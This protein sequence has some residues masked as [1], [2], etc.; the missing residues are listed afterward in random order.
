MPFLSFK[1]HI[2]T[3]I[4]EPGKRAIGSHGRIPSGRIYWAEEPKRLTVLGK[5]ASDTAQNCACQIKMRMK[6][7]LR[8]AQRTYMQGRAVAQNT[9]MIRGC[10]KRNGARHWRERAAHRSVAPPARITAAGPFARTAAP[11][12][13]PNAT[14][15]IG[16]G[17][18]FCNISLATAI[19]AVEV[20]LAKSMSGTCGGVKSQSSRPTSA[21]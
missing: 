11:R 7:G 8:D 10:R 15:R 17:R 20:D 16:P 13:N 12:K 6:S 2:S 18:G 14:R 19:A 5:L 21:T 1:V 3:H 4:K 9:A